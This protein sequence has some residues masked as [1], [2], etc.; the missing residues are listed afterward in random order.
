[1][2]AMMLTAVLPAAA[3]P[4]VG[5]AT[6]GEQVIRRDKLHP[7][8]RRQVDQAPAGAQF[9]VVVKGREKARLSA[10]AF[11][12]D[13]VVAALKAAAAKSQGPIVQY[14]RSRGA[15]VTGQFWL[16]NAVVARLDR[17]TLEGLVGLNDVAAVFDNFRVTAPVT[18]GPGPA[19][20]P[21]GDQTWGLAKIE[22]ARVWNELGFTGQGVRVAV[23]DTGVDISHPD[24]AGKLH[25]DNPGDPTYP[26]GWAEFDGD[27]RPVA[28]SQPHD[29][30][31]HG[32]HV[33]GTVA[34]GSA[35][36]TQI[37]VAPGA[38]L[39][40][41][42]VLP[43][44]GGSFAQV[45][46]GM[47]WAVQPTDGNGN[48]AGQPAHI[49]SVSF[50]AEGLRTE[51]VEPIRNMYNAGVLPIAAI[52]NCGSGCVGSPGAVFEAFGI[53]ASA[54]DDSIADFSSGDLIRK[55]GWQSPPEEWPD[56]W[57]KP[58]ISAP[59]VNVFS[60]VPGGGYDSWNGT[61]M[62]TPHVS[63]T[64]A[65]MLGANPS[66]T[67]EA[68]LAT[69]KETSY[70]D[71]R[72][73]E[74]RPNIR[75]GQG[76]IN[77]VE[78]V[79]RI[80][81]NSGISGV[82]T[83]GATGAPLDQAEVRVTGLNRTAKTRSNGSYS[84][85][86]PPG[87][88]SLTVS[89]FGY[90]EVSVGPVVVAEG[91]KSRADAALSALPTGQ[92][93]GTVRYSLSGIGIPGVSLRVTGVPIKIEATTDVDGAYAFSL[94][95]GSY[96]LQI[97]GY[98]FG[99]RQVSGLPVTPG[100]S[101]T[102]DVS[103]EP[104][105]RVAVIGDADDQISR[106]LVENGFQAQPAWFDVAREIDQYHAVVVNLVGKAMPEEVTGLVDAA[107]AAGVGLIFT[108]GDY[109][110]WGIDLL[111][112]VYGD[113]VSTGYGWNEFPVVAQVS[114]SHDA[115]LPGRAV[116][117]TFELVPP[118]LTT[119]WFDGY[120]GQTLAT[121]H[122]DM[123][124]QLGAGVAVKQ[125]GLSRHVLLAAHG[126]NYWQG[127]S[128]WNLAARE[129]FLN[130]IRWSARPETDGPRFVLW[131]LKAQPDTVLWNEP[132][133]V[134]VSV[135]NIG[136]VTGHHDVM[137]SVDDVPEGV[138][139]YDLHPGQH[140]TAQFTVQREK[141]GA[142]RAW[143]GHLSATFRV[144]PPKV[145]VQAQTLYLPPSGKGRNADPGEP[146]IPL[147]GAQV[148]IVKGGQ[149]ISRGKL[150]LNGRLTFDS[151][152]SRDDYVIV[153]RRES[154]GYN[155]QRHYLLTMPVH[156][157][158]DTSFSF[159]PLAAGVAVVESAL[160]ARG[161]SH[162]GTLFV[163]GGLLGQAAYEVP[164][165][166]LVLTP[167]DYRLA[168][169]MA[170]DV[171]GA[172]WAY[173]SEWESR[174]L[175]AEKHAYS[176]G[177]DLSLRMSDV[178]GQAA[179]SAQVGW[180]MFDGSSHEIAAIYQVTAGAFGPASRRVV[181]DASSWPATVAATAKDERKPVLT[182]TNPAG[183]IEQTG[184]IG[185]AEQPKAVSM[186]VEQVKSG[187][188]GLH[189]LADTGPYMGT[190]QAASSLMLP[191]RSLSRA[192]VMPGDSFEVTVL[193]DAGASGDLTLTE[194]LPAG[195]R[196][197][198]QTSQPQ[199]AF[200]GSTW[201]WRPSGK[202]AYRP[203]QAVRVAYTIQVDTGVAAGV[204]GLAG[205]VAQGGAGRLVAGPQSVQVVR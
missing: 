110:G 114:A 90:G 58:D 26:G 129:L 8:L 44:G 150:D 18:Q 45:V 121:L 38:T 50:G 101:T 24:L 86:L 82:V 153:V 78:A 190:L 62:A 66:L 180:G 170:Y 6:G 59:G 11:R 113:P 141:V 37:G 20:G 77:A 103:L 104:L 132:V 88:Y 156:V 3:A 72:Y 73:G 83:D 36:G 30:D 87:T 74:E 53:G 125:N 16:I 54:E 10:V 144:R 92:L 115:L 185:W 149:V 201:T 119:G 120:S 197:V 122:T 128:H 204:Y 179:P 29:S 67:P 93:A 9:T 84:L 85:V 76:R 138:Q 178:R 160:V 31:Q 173:A 71:N 41:G 131:D 117:D 28:G 48:P 17:P 186:P 199:S 61:S 65:L 176:F 163:S 166:T 4:S 109:I 172:Q 102:Y 27:G 55:S 15:Q 7:E 192:L 99:T 184:P 127:P 159:A 68:I 198:R 14:L 140:A 157:E 183:A 23:L 203:G 75:F 181:R 135:K 5:T 56:E 137:L 12:H 91:Q 112:D 47:Q 60:A 32:T 147:A 189:L 154:Y 81:Y 139:G 174:S 43:G 111:R 106:F 123:A 34:G 22:A 152:E 79:S 161:A 202:G 169:V 134:S 195:F 35:S 40:G 89:R 182:L 95:E 63:G 118:Y 25:S 107:A 155:S 196:V 187:E 193:F 42:L 124:G 205:S 145:T 96:G 52:G 168:N 19:P 33:S 130:A 98:G 194:S 49:A 142:Y 97:S 151:T 164:T 21:G 46:A 94:P 133:G 1:M 108:K 146:A 51:V 57:V 191:A 148:D 177:G 188:Y 39:M 162:H 69:L 70:W 100:Q 80:A 116:G 143:V 64:A 171:P 13:D 165:G 2:T 105:P 167:G 126:V 136:G 158:A 200:G 175:P